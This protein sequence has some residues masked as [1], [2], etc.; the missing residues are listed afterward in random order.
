VLEQLAVLW[1]PST[2]RRAEPAASPASAV[3]G[4]RQESLSRPEPAQDAVAELVSALL[5]GAV[6][7][8]T[9]HAPAWPE[10]APLA[11]A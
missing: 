1:A 10:L 5:A 2:E 4:E 11:Q 3:L 8:A 6:H 9:V 7:P